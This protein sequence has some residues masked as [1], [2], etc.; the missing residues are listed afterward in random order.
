MN[1]ILQLFGDNC[2]FILVDF[3]QTNAMDNQL[4]I[5]FQDTFWE[6][7]IEI[8]NALSKIENNNKHKKEIIDTTSTLA[9]INSNS[10]LIYNILA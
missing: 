10:C 8:D 7:D 2:W 4:G 3:L 9:E 5:L 1:K 6:L